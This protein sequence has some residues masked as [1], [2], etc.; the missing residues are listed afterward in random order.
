MTTYQLRQWTGN[1]QEGD[2]SLRH[3][4]VLVFNR[5]HACMHAFLS[6]S[7]SFINFGRIK[8]EEEE[9]R[10]WVVV[11]D[12]MEGLIPLVIRAI[13]RT[14]VRSSDSGLLRSA[15]CAV[16]RSPL[17]MPPAEEQWE[18]PQ[19]EPLPSRHRRALSELLPSAPLPPS[20]GLIPRPS[21]QQSLHRL[22][23]NSCRRWGRQF[24]Q[25]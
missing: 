24:I 15:S 11:W 23:S 6:T 2:R 14:R 4:R 7:I 21:Q 8:K 19:H 9:V 25:V 13:K 5:L 18:P 1:L 12:S 10:N 17:L 3:S 22:R 20:A 16:E